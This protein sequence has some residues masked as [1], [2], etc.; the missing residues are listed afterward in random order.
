M[1][2]LEYSLDFHPYTLLRVYFRVMSFVSVRNQSIVENYQV[3]FTIKKSQN[4]S[5]M[6][7]GAT[8]KEPDQFNIAG[9]NQRKKITKTHTQRVY[10]P[11]D[12]IADGLH[13]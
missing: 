8:E 7:M 1:T 2:A 4:A 12:K 9:I 6:L 10:A 3:K 11:Q 5:K 13:E